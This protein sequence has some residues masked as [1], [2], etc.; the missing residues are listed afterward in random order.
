MLRI[1]CCGFPVGLSR[2]ARKLPVVEVQQTF[3]RIPRR[4][5]IQRWRDA[6]PEDFIFTVKAWQGVTHPAGSPTYRKA[7]PLPPDD[8]MA[9][10]GH[11]RPTE[12]VF[13]AWKDTLQAAEILRAPV[14]LL[15]SPPSFGQTA[16]HEGNLSEF[17]GGIDRGAARIAL[18]LRAPWDRKS[19]AALCRK[20]DLIHCVDPFREDSVTGP[21]FY[22]RLHGS[23]P[24]LR[25]VG[26][27]SGLRPSGSPP[28]KRM[29]TYRYTG[30]DLHLLRDRISGWGAEGEVFCLFNN[31]SMWEDALAYRDLWQAHHGEAG[32]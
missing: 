28:G 10:L 6:V 19:L 30:E 7:G 14:I 16:E 4:E 25:P 29:Y 15:Q 21:P 18:E 17:L 27:P 9:R 23:P 3:Y 12:P 1:G 20:S 32:S 22:L 24:G 8:V 11:F 13:A 5:T 31:L 26:S 2:Y